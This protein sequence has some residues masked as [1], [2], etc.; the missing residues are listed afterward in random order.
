MAK[1][2]PT[3]L[4]CKRCGDPLL[5]ARVKSPSQGWY[6]PD[7]YHKVFIARIATDLLVTGS[8]YYEVVH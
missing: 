1:V 8:H 5:G 2:T 3:G 4:C 6:C 7:C